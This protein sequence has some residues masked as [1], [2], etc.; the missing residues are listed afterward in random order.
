MPTI[1]IPAV[2]SCV[3]YRLTY[4]ECQPASQPASLLD[5]LRPAACNTNSEHADCAKAQAVSRRPFHCGGPRS[6]PSRSMWVSWRTKWHLH[7]FF[8]QY[9]F[10]SYQYYSA[11]DSYPFIRNGRH[12]LLAT[13]GAIKSH[14]SVAMVMFHVI[15]TN[16]FVLLR[17]DITLSQ[18][19]LSLEYWAIGVYR[20]WQCSALSDSNDGGDAICL[21]VHKLLVDIWNFLVIGY[22]T[23]MA[24]P[25]SSIF[26]HVFCSIV[27]NSLSFYFLFPFPESSSFIRSY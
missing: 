23:V 6:V 16:L 18:I 22:R 4:S 15:F 5:W 7:K 12:M 9:F 25:F 1:H 2:C 14:G 27:H 24:L 8:A 20:Y 17:V 13:A 3:S 10:S 21:F 26:V 11:S 19:C